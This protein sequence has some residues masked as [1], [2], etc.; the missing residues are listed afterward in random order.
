M[1]LLCIAMFCLEAPVAMY[2]YYMMNSWI[3]FHVGFP[4]SSCFLVLFM[5]LSTCGQIHNN[6]SIIL[7]NDGLCYCLYVV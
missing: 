4:S 5:K 3:T 7:G 1:S 6:Y 2:L